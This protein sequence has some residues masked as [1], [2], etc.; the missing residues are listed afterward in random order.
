K[1]TP[2]KAYVTISWEKTGIK[3]PIEHDVKSQILKDI[4][5]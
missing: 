1:F 3:F 2:T 4:S 5:E